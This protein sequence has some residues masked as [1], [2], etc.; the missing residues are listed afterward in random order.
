MYISPTIGKD[1]KGF[2]YDDGDGVIVAHKN[3]DKFMEL[4][5]WKIRAGLH[6]NNEE[7]KKEA[8]KR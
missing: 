8:E 4:I 5:K 1:G 3:F 7:A 6:V 2:L